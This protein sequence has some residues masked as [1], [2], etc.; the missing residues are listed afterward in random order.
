MGKN[1]ALITGS[2]SGHR[3]HFAHKVVTV[4]LH[5]QLRVSVRTAENWLRI[6]VRSRVHFESCANLLSA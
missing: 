5:L 4:R 3:R 1:H 6:S 2:W